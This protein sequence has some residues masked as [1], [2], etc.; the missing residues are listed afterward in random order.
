MQINHSSE[1]QTVVAYLIHY[2]DEGLS[3]ASTEASNYIVLLSR[4]NR[5]DKG[6]KFITWDGASDQ[7]LPSLLLG[8]DGD[9]W[10]REILR[11][12]EIK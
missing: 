4:E 11:G 8:V 5:L 2:V 6:W 9:G 1:I 3:I 12:I 10:T 7:S